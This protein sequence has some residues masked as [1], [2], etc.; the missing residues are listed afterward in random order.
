[1]SIY[2]IE[3]KTIDGKSET[4]DTFRGK[5]LLIVNVASRCGFTPQYQGLEAMYRQHKDQGL[6]VLGFP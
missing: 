2:D 5:T 1:M 6:A 3:V 4:L